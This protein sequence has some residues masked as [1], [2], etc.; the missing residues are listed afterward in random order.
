MKML[1]NLRK[2][3]A[4]DQLADAFSR[5]E[6]AIDTLPEQERIQN[7]ALDTSTFVLPSEVKGKNG[8]LALFSDGACRGNPG[9]GGWGYVIQNHEG[10]V[11]GEGSG[12][13]S[14]T[15]N[16]Q[17]ELTA[18]LEG[19]EAIIREPSLGGNGKHLYVY[20]DSQYLVNGMNS[21][22]EGWK[23][24]GWK[25][26][27]KKAPENLELWQQLDQLKQRF[28]KVEFKWVKGHAGHPQ[29]EYCDALA[30]KVLDE[31]GH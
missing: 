29:N 12:H 4:N 18:A 3:L 27:D 1:E 15:T 28:R 13:L 10:K 14:S 21:W 22:V 25:K 16:N 30:N 24:R 6:S 31:N 9:P 8:N 23:N 17:M 11:V 19:M 5:I 7:K 26:A 20:T 2:E